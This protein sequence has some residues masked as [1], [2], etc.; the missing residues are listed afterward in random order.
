[1]DYNQVVRR[2]TT[3]RLLRDGLQSGCE[4]TDYTRLLRDGLQSGCEE[5]DYNR[6]VKRWTTTRLLGDDGV[7]P[8]C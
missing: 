1:M 2:R 7:Q 6:F 3:T 5:T 8:G 4:E